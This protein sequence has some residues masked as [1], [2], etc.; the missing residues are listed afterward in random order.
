MSF[1]IY[2]TEC[3]CFLMQLALVTLLSWVLMG[4]ILPHP[5]A[6]SDTD[7]LITKT[8]DD[9][10]DVVVD[11]NLVLSF[12]RDVVINYFLSGKKTLFENYSFYT[13]SY[14]PWI[15]K[16]WLSQKVGNSNVRVVKTSMK[17]AEHLREINDFWE[18]YTQKLRFTNSYFPAS[19]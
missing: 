5:H 3:L 18:V 11:N 12:W 17:M 7:I 9:D 16:G 10:D 8:D 14:S 19:K 2:T 1:L 15:Y 13:R 6:I 4:P